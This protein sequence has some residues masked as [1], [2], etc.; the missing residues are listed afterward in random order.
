VLTEIEES[1]EMYG[2]LHLTRE[3]LDLIPLPQDEPASPVQAFCGI[4]V[5]V[6][7]N[8]QFSALSQAVK[9]GLVIAAIY[10]EDGVLKR[11]VF[12]GEVWKK[13]ATMAFTNVNPR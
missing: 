9:T 1:A 3:I 8:P 4:P 13:H 11:M 12:D 2:G 6:T 7:D 5:F 10:E